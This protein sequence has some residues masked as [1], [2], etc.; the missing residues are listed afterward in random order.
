MAG[1]GRSLTCQERPI[2]VIGT[3]RHSLAMKMHQWLVG[4]SLV[5]AAGPTF[6]VEICHTMAYTILW[7]YLMPL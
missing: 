7:T 1:R 2:A 6:A 4:I 5:L 3:T